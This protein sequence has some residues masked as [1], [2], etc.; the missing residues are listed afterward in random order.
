M[1]QSRI[2]S[3]EVKL[4][5]TAM[6]FPLIDMT[7]SDPTTMLTAMLKA[8]AITTDCGQSITVFTADQQLYHVMV[9]IRWVY[10]DLFANFVPRLGGMHLGDLAMN[11]IGCIGTLMSNSGLQ[12]ILEAAFAGV[13]AMLGEKVSSKFPVFTHGRRNSTEQNYRG[14]KT[15][16]Y[17]GT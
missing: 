6:Y 9:H 14:V 4:K 15:S 7:P 16:Q 2:D 13:Q 12:E 5:T 17:G 8:H 10:P 11:F 3:Q 1:Q